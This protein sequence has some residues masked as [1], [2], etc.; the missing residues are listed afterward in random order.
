MENDFVDPVFDISR[1]D[2]HELGHLEY[3]LNSPSYTQVFR[4]FLQATQKMYME[5]LMDPR[6]K[7]RAK[8]GGTN[9]LRCGANNAR[10]IL[11]FF[12]KILEET[13]DSRAMFARNALGQQD[14][15]EAAVA[16]GVI[17]HSGQT[18]KPEEDF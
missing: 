16:S 8:Y 1:L 15:Y 4:P 12:D 14:L 10:R 7:V 3:V 5:L 2:D 18:L 13:R 17:R 11:E 9:Y 6:P